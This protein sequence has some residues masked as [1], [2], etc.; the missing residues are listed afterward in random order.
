MFYKNTKAVVRT[1]DGDTYFINIVAG[2]L[3]GET[4]SP[5]LFIIS[6]DF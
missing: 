2:V 4:L 6:L 5:Y 1:P 3:Q